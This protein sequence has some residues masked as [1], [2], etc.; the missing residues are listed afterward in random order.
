MRNSGNDR[1]RVLHLAYRRRSGCGCSATRRGSKCDRGRGCAAKA[2]EVGSVARKDNRVNR[3]TGDGGGRGGLC[4]AATTSE[5]HCGSG[6]VA[7]ATAVGESHASHP[8]SGRT[9]T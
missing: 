3:T 1:G 7:T 8:E 9:V 2:L 4:R 6:G 5:G